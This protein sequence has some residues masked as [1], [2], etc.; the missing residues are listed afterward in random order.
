MMMQKDCLTGKSFADEGEESSI[1]TK[2]GRYVE[3]LQS[4]KL[5]QLLRQRGRLFDLKPCS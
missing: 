2:I 5:A 3:L 1:K 4:R